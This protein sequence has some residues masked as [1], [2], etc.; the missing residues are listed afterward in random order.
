MVLCPN[1]EKAI[2]E[3]ESLFKKEDRKNT[4][5]TYQK[6]LQYKRIPI[7]TLLNIIMVQ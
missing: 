1:T 7:K 3:F 6:H 5:K 2:G 4:T